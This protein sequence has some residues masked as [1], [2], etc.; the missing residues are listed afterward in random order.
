MR[1]PSRIVLVVLALAALVAATGFVMLRNRKMSLFLRARDRLERGEPP[2]RVL[3]DLRER[4]DWPAA[5][6]EEADA[7]A[8]EALGPDAGA[9]PFALHRAGDWALLATGAGLSLLERTRRGWTAR[10]SRGPAPRAR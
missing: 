7:I 8:R 5:P 2:E 3:G 9:G 4:I 6:P 10:S 1:R